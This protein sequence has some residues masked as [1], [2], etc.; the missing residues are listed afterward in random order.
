MTGRDVPTTLVR[1]RQR[2]YSLESVKRATVN[3]LGEMPSTFLVPRPRQAL[4]RPL[5]SLLNTA[6]YSLCVISARTA[7]VAGPAF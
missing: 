3:I 7:N 1:R 5:F 6:A 2:R 4:P